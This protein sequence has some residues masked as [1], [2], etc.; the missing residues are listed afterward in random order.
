MSQSDTASAA[1]TTSSSTSADVTSVTRRLDRLEREL[2]DREDRITELRGN[3][4]AATERVERLEQT[5][6]IARKELA[7]MAALAEQGAGAAAAT[8]G[9]KLVDGDFGAWT[10]DKVRSAFI[11]FFGRKGEAEAGSPL[12]AAKSPAPAHDFIRKSMVQKHP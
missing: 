12:A 6:A 3:N 11:D 5:L 4:Q 2:K 9:G 1:A 10:G 7:D 8:T